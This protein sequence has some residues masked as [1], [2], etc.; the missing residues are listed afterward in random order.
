MARRLSGIKHFV[1][2]LLVKTAVGF[3]I[4]AGGDAIVE[5]FR[6]PVLNDTGTFGDPNTS[7]Y[8][9]FSYALGTFGVVAGVADLGLRG[10]QGILGF[11]RHG[12]PFFAGFAMGTY[13]Y[14]HT[15]SKLFGL[16][17]W[18]P[19]DIVGRAFPPLLPASIPHPGITPGQPFPG[20][21]EA[22]P[23]TGAKL[24]GYY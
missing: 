8:E 6:L 13:F 21:R 14:E 11:T 2:E 7:N 16:R 5:I 22:A 10:G 17:D 15:L 4:G 12:M 24:P 19:Y 1:L 9:Y 20:S 23:A 3:G 18:N